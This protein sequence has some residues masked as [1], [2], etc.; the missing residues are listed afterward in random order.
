MTDYCAEHGAQCGKVCKL[1]EWKDGHDKTS[2]YWRS[3]LTGT[4]VM[5]A[6]NLA[7]IIFGY[8][9]LIN[10]FETLDKIVKRNTEFIDNKIMPHV[11]IGNELNR[12]GQ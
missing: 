2:A 3:F 8:G 9:K 6:V 11:Y 12:A 7:V 1:E 5:V 10:S 4:A